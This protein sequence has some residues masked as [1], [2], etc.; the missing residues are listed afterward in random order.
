MYYFFFAGFLAGF[1]APVLGFDFLPVLQ[2]QVLHIFVPPFY[3]FTFVYKL[4]YSI[5]R[6]EGKSQA[7]FD[8]DY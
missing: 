7:L 8:N 1:F 4:L 5:G 6:G 3:E 2:P